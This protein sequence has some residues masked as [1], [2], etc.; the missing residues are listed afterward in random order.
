MVVNDVNSKID[1][2]IK[3]FESFNLPNYF[4][5]NLMAMNSYHFANTFKCRDGSAMHSSLKKI[6]HFPN[7]IENKMEYY[8]DG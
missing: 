3:L 5:I 8:H 7:F 1:L 4:R 6:D 2:S